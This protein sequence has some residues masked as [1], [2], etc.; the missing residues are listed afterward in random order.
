[1]VDITLQSYSSNRP[2]LV[3]AKAIGCRSTSTRF[4]WQRCTILQRKVRVSDACARR[5]TG[6]A[7]VAVVS[8]RELDEQAGSVGASGCSD[9][10]SNGTDEAGDGSGGDRSDRV[11]AAGVRFGYVLAVA[12]YGIS[13]PGHNSRTCLGGRY[14]VSSQGVPCR[15][16]DDLA[17]CW[18]RHRPNRRSPSLAFGVDSRVAR[19]G[20]SPIRTPPRYF[21]PCDPSSSRWRSRSGPRRRE[22]RQRQ[23]GR[24]YIL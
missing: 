13:A 10:I 19:Y 2:R 18:A 5:S 7:G 8:S 4:V 17:G 15:C 14:S 1:V 24:S 16:A 20:H 12:G 21:F 22:C 23:H 9:R 6:H 11:I 3:L